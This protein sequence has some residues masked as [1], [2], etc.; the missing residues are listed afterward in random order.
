MGL[1]KFVGDVKNHKIDLIDHLKFISHHEI[2]YRL[3]ATTPNKKKT[4][5][6]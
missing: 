1:K 5:N 3:S 4:Q 2:Q 6:K